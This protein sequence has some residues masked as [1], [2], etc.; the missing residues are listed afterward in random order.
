[1]CF[2]KIVLS[3][4]Y[5]LKL[6]EELCKKTHCANYY[7]QQ[8]ACTYICTCGCADVGVYTVHTQSN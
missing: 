6:E 1:M 4:L 7:I 2:V 5:A 8:F 3:I